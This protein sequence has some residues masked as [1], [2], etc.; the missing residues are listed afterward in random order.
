MSTLENLFYLFGTI[1][2]FS[3]LVFAYYAF[4]NARLMRGPLGHQL[5]AMGGVLFMAATIVGAVDHFFLPGSGLVYV[6]FFIWIAGL[7]V[8][9][10]GGMLRVKEIQRIYRVPLFRILTMMPPARFYSVGIAVLLFIS[11]PI[12]TLSVLSPLR[13]KPRWLNVGNTILWA[14]AFVI[15]AMAERRLHLA[16]RP[17]AA[18][19]VAGVEE[20]LL[21]EDILALRA[22]SDLTNRL[23]ATAIPAIGAETLR[24]VLRKCA[25]EHDILKDCEMTDE[26]TL[27]VERTVENLT[28]ISEKEG[29]PKVFDGFSNLL[30]RFIDLYSA[31]ASPELAQEMLAKNYQATKERYGDI[32]IFLRILKTMPEGFLEEEKLALLSREELEAKVKERTKELEEALIKAREA[33]EALRASKASFHNIVERSADGIIIVNRKGIV[34]FVNPAAESLFGR[35]AEDLIGELFDFPIVAGGVAELDIIRRSGEKG[36]GELRVV[37]TEWE[38]EIAY[39]AL[40]RDITERKRAEEEI[41]RRSEELEALREIS[42]AITA[43]LE[44]G[45]LLQNIVE[46]GCRLLGVGAGSV[47]LVDEKSGDLELIVSHGY[48]RDYSGSRLAPGEGIAR[49][50]LQNGEPLAVDDYHHWEGRSLDWE[51][52]PITGCV[53]VPLK[54]GERIIGVLGF[55]EIARARSFDEHDVWLTTLFASQAAIAIE[56]ARLYEETR[57]H[58][59]RLSTLYEVGQ[60]ITSTLDLDALLQSIANQTVRVTGAERSLIWLINVAEQEV[61][62]VVGHGYEREYLESLT[63]QEFWDGLAGWVFREKTP[64]LTED[65]LKDERVG[66]L[67]RAK[68]RQLNTRSVA[69]A[70]LLTKGEAIGI[71]AILNSAGGRVFDQADLDLIAMLASQVSIAIENARLFEAERGQ[72]EL[73]EALGEAAAAVSSTLDPDQ[74][75]DRILEQVERVVAG[76]VFNIM[77]IED[78]AARAVRWR[79]YERL[80]GEDFISHFTIPIARYPSLTRMVQ[81]GKPIVVPDTAVHPDWVWQEEEMWMRSYV[82]APILVSGVT[83]G[84]LN[85]GGTQPG[86]FGPADARRLQAF[87]DHAAAAIENARL[88]EQA[89]QEIAERKRAEEELQRALERLRKAMGGVIQAMALAVETKD[90]YTAGHQRRVANLARA[91][92]AEMGLSP[93]QIDGI[94]MAAV[95]H[96]LGKIS[97][98]AEILSKP[99]GL[100]D[101]EYGLIKIHPQ[102]GYD[103]LKEIEFP[104]PVAQIVLQHHERMDG[105]GYPQGLLGEEIILEARI[106]AVADV[107]EAMASHRPYRPPHGVDKALEEI[108]R[109]RGILY[110][111]EVVDACLKLFNEKGFKLG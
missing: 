79:G 63:F 86:Q 82:G 101:L 69:L 49:R 64:T 25:D 12:S 109:N 98:P 61:T 10:S 57:K 73:A 111:P 9:V 89:Q 88:F 97:V 105:S 14:F 94:R 107:V 78:D 24:D 23:L 108:S 96:D 104:W 83:V 48:T 26:G 32:P 2:F 19:P 51:A 27:M 59:D 66:E 35:K 17:S 7:S 43:Q 81:S 34:C 71:L 5:M 74:V 76:D 40:L 65:T 11:L 41:K 52:E 93:E 20:M 84:V 91:I 100:N 44:L 95:I 60:E 92:A 85:V 102:V 70:P 16:M 1:F 67:A 42:L 55:A 80:G 103:I 13:P 99:I 62:K 8:I 90:A 29:I 28:N 53:G 18:A 56:N 38:G 47:Y 87:A 36:V 110:D 6:E 45:A 30:S 33:T 50:V 4:K 46:Q 39:L 77:L 58:L 15:M 54:R 22:Y 106:L 72:R 3:T 68:S 31:V 75:L 21:R 37:E